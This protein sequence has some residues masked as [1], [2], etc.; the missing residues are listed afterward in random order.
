MPPINVQGSEDPKEE[1]AAAVEHLVQYL[2]GTR[3]KGI[4][5]NPRG[6][7]LIDVH[8]DSDFSGNWNKL[9]AADDAS[10]AKSRTGYLISF[11]KCCYL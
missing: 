11:S 6:K 3:N 9:T 1:H 10:T 5:M 7:P 4:I 8:A 2:Y